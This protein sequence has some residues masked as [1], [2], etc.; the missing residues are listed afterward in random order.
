MPGCWRSR[1]VWGNGGGVRC[2][3]T[4]VI[5]SRERRA[6]IVI[7]RDVA[8]VTSAHRYTPRVGRVIRPRRTSQRRASEISLDALPAQVEPVASQDGRH[9][10]PPQTAAPQGRV[11]GRVD[12]SD[13]GR[14]GGGAG[15][16]GGEQP[17]R[18]RREQRHAFIV[19]WGCDSERPAGR[20]ASLARLFSAAC[21]LI[22]GYSDS[23]SGSGP[24][25]AIVAMTRN[26]RTSSAP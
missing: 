21:L 16:L 25:P 26:R 18:G 23:D 15:R 10:D 14:A 8:S 2:E 11:V 9:P 3:R 12:H 6:R 17:R 13:G 1:Q 24:S 4:A 19:P 20:P 22:S 5:H 7:R